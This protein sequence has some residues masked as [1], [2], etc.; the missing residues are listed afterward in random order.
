MS[1]N[2]IPYISYN[3]PE[4]I[5]ANMDE[6]RENIFMNID[7]RW[8]DLNSK[9]RPT[10]CSTNCAVATTNSQ[11]QLRTEIR[12]NIGFGLDSGQSE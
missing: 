9:Q 2:L 7:R 8:M 4:Y 6:P 10:D 12:L 1:Y 3:G 5:Y 11:K